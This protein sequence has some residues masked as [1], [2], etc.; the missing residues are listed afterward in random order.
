[1][2]KKCLLFSCLSWILFGAPALMADPLV[3][4]PSGEFACSV[5]VTPRQSAPP[6]PAHSV[7]ANAQPV[8]EKPAVIQ[9]VNILRA[10]KLQRNDTTWSDGQTSE[11]WILID[12]D[13]ALVEETIGLN[14]FIAKM[15]KGTE[16][17]NRLCP[18]ILDLDAGSMSWISPRSFTGTIALQGKPALHYQ[19]TRSLIVAGGAPRIL[20]FQAWIDAKTLA[21][22]ALDDGDALYDLTFFAPPDGPLVMPVRFQQELQHYEN[23]TATLKHL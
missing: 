1:M 23:S 5:A 15:P 2:N 14:T 4:L 16:K 22:L 12:R 6:A 20:L 8:P 13:L 9:S 18:T 21:P 11:A 17:L 3:V 19:A 7:P 10:G